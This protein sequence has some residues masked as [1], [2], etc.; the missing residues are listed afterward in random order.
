MSAV[1]YLNI[2]STCCRENSVTRI[3]QCIKELSRKLC[4]PHKVKWV[5]NAHDVIA[6]VL[7]GSKIN[8]SGSD[9]D[10]LDEG[11]HAEYKPSSWEE[12]CDSPIGS[13]TVC[14]GANSPLPSTSAKGTR[15]FTSQIQHGCTT[16]PKGDSRSEFESTGF[17]YQDC[18]NKNLVSNHQVNKLKQTSHHQSIKW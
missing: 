1:N 13:I 3:E 15:I 14:Q 10:E 5:F 6:A 8:I 11:Q 9:D 4:A 7:E 17:P 12:E 16:Y 2:C 18:C